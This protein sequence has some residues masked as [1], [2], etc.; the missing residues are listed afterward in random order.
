MKRGY[1]LDKYEIP[2]RIEK[3]MG[4]YHDPLDSTINRFIAL[5]IEAA[6]YF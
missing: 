4:I 1:Q 2:L 5:E 3:T 6:N